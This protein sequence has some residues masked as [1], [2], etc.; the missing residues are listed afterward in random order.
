MPQ[1]AKNLIKTSRHF[2]TLNLLNTD[3]EGQLQAFL[4]YKPH[5]THVVLNL[6]C[7]HSEF[8]LQNLS[9]NKLLNGSFSILAFT[10]N[11]TAS[12]EI[13]DKQNINYDSE[14]LLIIDQQTAKDNYEIYQ[15]RSLEHWKGTQLIVES[16]GSYSK[17]HFELRPLNTFHDFE[18]H[19]MRITTNVSIT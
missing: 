8:I 2:P 7:D 18:R 17:H 10:S 19:T 1:L 13:L 15:V 3:K 4:N 9:D 16:V 5:N 14:I 6:E 11:W 12:I